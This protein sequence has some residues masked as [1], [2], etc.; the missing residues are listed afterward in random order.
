M[1]V[2][3]RFIRTA[4]RYHWAGSAVS[5]S[6]EERSPPAIALVDLSRN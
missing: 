4:N 3:G 6:E 5:H 2:V 1:F